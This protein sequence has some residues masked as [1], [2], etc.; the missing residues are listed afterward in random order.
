MD[1]FGT[2]Y[3]SLN[4]LRRYPFDSIKI[5]RQFVVAARK[6]GKDSAIVR[7]IVELGRKIGM[8]TVAEGVETEEDLAMLLELGCA[9][10]QGYLFGRPLP[11]EEIEEV[12]A[13]DARRRASDRRMEAA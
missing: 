3:S 12:I 6:G 13:A 11:R 1:D 5:D 2:G 4:Y 10:G 9:E 7:A 8:T